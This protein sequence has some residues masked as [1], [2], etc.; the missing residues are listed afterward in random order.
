TSTA[1]DI[2]ASAETS[3]TAATAEAPAAEPRIA[4]ARVAKTTTRLAAERLPE[5][6]ELRR[7]RMNAE[8][9]PVVE[10]LAFGRHDRLVA[11]QLLG[12]DDVVRQAGDLGDRQDA[13]ASVGEP[14]DL[15]DEVDRIGDLAA[16]A[17]LGGLEGR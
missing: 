16:Q 15:H 6:R 4:E 17:P 3:A 10:F 1:L 9:H 2:E 13:A 14:A 8:R 11:I 5:T 7:M 12:R